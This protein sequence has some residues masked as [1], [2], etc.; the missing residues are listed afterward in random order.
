MKVIYTDQSYDSLDDLTQFLINELEW[1][2]EKV[3]ELRIKVLDKAD[4]LESNYNHYQEE[5]Y[6]D[7]LEKGHRRAIEG[8]VKIIYRVDGD[9]L[10]HRLL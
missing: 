1:N 2:L 9:D 7:H 3:L 10:Y 8:S 5:E 4:S 6:L